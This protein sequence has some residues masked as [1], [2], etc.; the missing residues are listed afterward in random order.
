MAVVYETWRKCG[1]H[2]ENLSLT[3]LQVALSNQGGM[4][5][6][7]I[8]SSFSRLLIFSGTCANLEFR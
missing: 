4:D 6:A 8:V 7:K 3:Q 5:K 2:S 1:G